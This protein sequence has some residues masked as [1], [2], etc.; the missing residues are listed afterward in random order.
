[1][2]AQTRRPLFRFEEDRI[3]S[4]HY[5][6]AKTFAVSRATISSSLV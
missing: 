2:E 6:E 1:M 3:R 5:A 4:T